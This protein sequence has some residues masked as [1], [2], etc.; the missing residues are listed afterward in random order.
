MLNLS[1]TLGCP[2]FIKDKDIKLSQ[3]MKIEE[4]NNAMIRASTQHLVQSL[5]RAHKLEQE[6]SQLAEMRANSEK[7]S[8]LLVDSEAKRSKETKEKMLPYIFFV[9]KLKSA[10]SIGKFFIIQMINLLLKTLH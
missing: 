8:K 3:T 6:K 4:E 7:L 5:G 10:P 1:W 9:M 2:L